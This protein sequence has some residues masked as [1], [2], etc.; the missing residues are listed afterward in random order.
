MANPLHT[1]VT[2]RVQQCNQ[3]REKVGDSWQSIFRDTKPK[4][5]PPP[6]P[7]W[8]YTNTHTFEL[9][10][11]KMKYPMSYQ[12]LAIQMLERDWDS[13]DTTTYT[14]V[15]ATHNNTNGG[16]C[17]IV[18]PGSLATLERMVGVLIWSENGACPSKL[19][20]ILC[21]QPSKRYDR[22]FPFTIIHFR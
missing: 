11:Q 1:I 2:Q 19:R 6:N 15:S 20:K 18:T 16:S 8:L 5:N 7:P 3:K 12:A 10:G 9:I 13:F 22:M 17:I 4:P 14:D 21:K